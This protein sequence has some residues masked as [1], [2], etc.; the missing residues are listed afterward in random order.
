[1]AY[2]IRPRTKDKSACLRFSLMSKAPAR[3]PCHRDPGNKDPSRSVMLDLQDNS[4]CLMQS[5]VESRVLDLIK[6]IEN[7]VQA[8]CLPVAIADHPR[9][10]YLKVHKVSSFRSFDQIPPC[11]RK[12]SAVHLSLVCRG[13]R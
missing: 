2:T 11:C 5:V 6:P 13:C 10:M 4:K 1:M 3:K 7:D 12:T 8:Q 9:W